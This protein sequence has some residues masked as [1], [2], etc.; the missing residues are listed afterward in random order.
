MKLFRFPVTEVRHNIE[1][2]PRIEGLIPGQAFRVLYREPPKAAYRYT[3]LINPLSFFGTG[4][5]YWETCSSLAGMLRGEHGADNMEYGKANLALLKRPNGADTEY[6]LSQRMKP[7]G[8]GQVYQLVFSSAAKF[9]VGSQEFVVQGQ[10]EQTQHLKFRKEGGVFIPY[11]VEFNRYDDRSSKDKKHVP[12]QHRVCILKKTQVNE[13][14]DP[15]M[16]EIQ[17]LGLRYGDRMVDRIENEM[18]VFNGKNFVPVNQFKQQTTVRTKGVARQNRSAAEGRNLSLEQNQSINKMK[19]IGLAMMEYAA[20]NGHFPPAYL[21]NQNGKP[22]LSWRVIILPYI[23]FEALYKQF[24][25]DEPWDSQHN[26]RLIAQMPTVYKSPNSGVSDQGK[27]NYLTVRGP[28]TVFPGKKAIGFAEIRDGTS[29]TIITVEASDAKAV[30][31]TKPDDFEYNPKTPLSGLIGLRPD[32]FLAGL[33]DGSVRFVWSSIAP[34][35]LKAFFTRN[36]GKKVE[37]EALGR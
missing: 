30:V 4:R 32:G 3:S 37:T 11:E 14:I 9:N 7:A 13:P 18:Q 8:S 24:H 36:G 28:D 12:A 16:F 33:A 2:F 15:A 5:P 31:W 29:N 17:S 19:Q 26:K 23:G 22:L 6:I 34:R 25:L 21:A 35:D 20:G 10:P 27:T 1:G